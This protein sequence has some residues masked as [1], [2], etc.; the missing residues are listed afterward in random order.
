MK[1]IEYEE[2]DSTQLE[3]KRYIKNNSAS[4][5][6]VIIAKNQTSGIGTHGRKWIAKKDE[7]ITFTL[8]LEPNCKLEKLENF[9]VDIAEC[10]VNTFKELYGISLEIKKP[11]DIV[12]NGKKIGGILTE[13]QVLEGMVKYVFI[14]IGLNTN[15]TEFA[16]EIAEIATSVK[17][18]FGINI[19]NRKVIENIVKKI[20]LKF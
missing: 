5:G 14:G 15:Q 17:N 20:C 12:Y 8:I 3:A 11:N 1:Y 16:P 4:N 10:I 19:D 18:E 9:T 2:L 7:S 13:T 6:T